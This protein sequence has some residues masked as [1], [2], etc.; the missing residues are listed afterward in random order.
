[1]VVGS[2]EA[3]VLPVSRQVADRVPKID[4]GVQKVKTRPPA[5]APETSDAR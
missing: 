5:A 4:L 2:R 3:I 1:M